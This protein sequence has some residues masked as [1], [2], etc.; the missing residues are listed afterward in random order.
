MPDITPA[1]CI[2]CNAEASVRAWG[3]VCGDGGTSTTAWPVGGLGTPGAGAGTGAVAP[4]ADGVRRDAG[5]VAGAAAQPTAG[6]HDGA[7]AGA[8]SAPIRRV[9]QRVPVELDSQR[10]GGL[11]Q[12]PA[13]AKRPRARHDPLLSRSGGLLPGL[14]GRRSLRVGGRV[15]GA[16]RDASGADLPRV[17]HRRARRR[18]R[19]QAGPAAVHPR[20][21]AGVLRLRRRPGGRRPGGWPQGLAGGVSRRDTVQSD[22]RVGPTA[23]GVGDAGRG[24]LHHQSGGSAVG[25]VRHVGGALRQSDARVTR[26]GGGRSP[27]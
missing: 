2:G 3:R 25:S 18:L 21:A 5:R 20:G 1:G 7:V 16:V 12:Q 11:D 9:R 26:R 13:I 19:R 6:G 4:R 8:D 23:A 17:E 14:R 27:R 10:C 24:R 22:L 15:R